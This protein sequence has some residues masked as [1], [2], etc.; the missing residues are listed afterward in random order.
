MKLE[1]S[2]I[3]LLMEWYTS[4]VFKLMP[5]QEE[6]DKKTKLKQVSGAD[7]KSAQT[8]AVRAVHVIFDNNSS[9]EEISI[10]PF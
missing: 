9:T 3:F 2:L 7:A 6:V 1:I 5:Q 4:K 10:D 8:L